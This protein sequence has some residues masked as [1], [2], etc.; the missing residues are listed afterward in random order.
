MFLLNLN[1][2]NVI[3]KFNN[4]INNNNNNTNNEDNKFLCV[5]FLLVRLNYEIINFSVMIVILI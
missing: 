4:N 2:N 3:N 1:N 5:Y